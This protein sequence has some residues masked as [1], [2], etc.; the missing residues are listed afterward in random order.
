LKGMGENKAKTKTKLYSRCT[1]WRCPFRQCGQRWPSSWAFPC[2]WWQ[3]IALRRSS[4]QTTQ[5]EGGLTAYKPGSSPASPTPPPP[6]TRS[7]W[8][9]PNPGLQNRHRRRSGVIDISN[10]ISD[11]DLKP[12]MTEISKFGLRSQNIS[13]QDLKTLVWD[14]QPFVAQIS[15]KWFEIS[16][17]LSSR[18]QIL[19]WDP[20]PFVSKTGLRSQTICNRDLK[21]VWDPKPFLIEISN[22]L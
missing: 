13:N 21:M 20:K 10:P 7:V 12:F 19:V 1:F 3:A 6:P 16:N 22:Y 4:S 5:E 18:F 11:W 9:G 8:T 2:S 15:K 17:H 14:L